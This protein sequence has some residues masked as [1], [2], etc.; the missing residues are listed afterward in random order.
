MTTIVLEPTAT[1]NEEVIQNFKQALTKSLIQ[2]ASAFV[3]KDTRFLQE[4]IYSLSIAMQVLDSKMAE[5]PEEIG[6]L[7]TKVLTY[8]EMINHYLRK[9]ITVDFLE[10]LKGKEYAMP[11]LEVLRDYEIREGN[12]KSRIL[13]LDPVSTDEEVYNETFQYLTAEGL[14]QEKEGVLILGETASRMF[15]VYSNFKRVTNKYESVKRAH[16]TAPEVQE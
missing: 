13:G 14:V 9:D 8:I 1:T 12:L 5:N 6:V 15:E 2:I 11:I 4:E 10:E 16:S 3:S 7:K